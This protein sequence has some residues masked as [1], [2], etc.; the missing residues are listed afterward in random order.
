[1]DFLSRRGFLHSSSLAAAAAV[2]LEPATAAVT[3][4]RSPNERPVFGWIGSGI[5][6]HNLVPQVCAYGPLA[7]VCDVDAVQRGR[8]V[9]SARQQHR[10]RSYPIDIYD[11][12]DY[13]AVLD[14]SDIDAIFISTP[15]H[16]HARVAVDAM[17][18]GKDV[19]CEKPMTLTIAE[20]RWVA[21]E[22]RRTGRVLQ[23][24]TQQRSDFDRR[25]AI[26]A[27]LVREGRIG[28]TRRVTCSVGGCPVGFPIPECAPPK[29]LNW[30]LW[31]GPAPWTPYLA[32]P[33]IVQTD[34]Y[35][36]GHPASRTHHYFRWWYEYSGGRLA[37]WGAHHV[38]VAMWALGKD[39]AGAGAF[40]LEPLHVVH[41]SPLDE[42]GMPVHADR[43]HTACE[44]HV[45]VTFEDGVEL[46]I[47]DDASALLGFDNGIMFQGDSGRHF[48][49]RGKLTGRPVE[50][51][52]EN[53]L[54]E[55]A[56][57][58][59]YGRSV[60]ATDHVGD[61]VDCVRSNAAPVSDAES[62]HRCL[63]V[64]HAANIALRLGRK[65]RFDPA[66]ETFDDALAQSFVERE[67]RGSW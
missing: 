56:L 30:D 13:R 3:A 1:M 46:D 36:A 41:A 34:G 64:C 9:Q 24:G 39:N 59:L 54:P 65:V 47:I 26:A 63:T 60:T 15:D 35:G 11:Y 67:R 66:T 16:W 49:N 14:R 2:G 52:G 25:F 19:Y 45:R 6:F 10:D 21:D 7:A 48:V 33:E 40:T 4:A 62:H 51:L 22:V 42:R 55:D 58:R 5:R 20:G 44:F 18:A 57:D 27:A 61:F 38:D 43:Y 8:G 37:D 32:S 28:N 29:H 12:E 50:E 17:Q 31:L 53:P 23:V